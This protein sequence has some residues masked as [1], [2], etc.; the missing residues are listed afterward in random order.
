MRLFVESILRYGLPPKFLAALMKP[1]QK[2]VPKL[3]KI[4]ATT[5]GAGEPGRCYNNIAV[6]NCSGRHWQQVHRANRRRR[7]AFRSYILRWTSSICC[8]LQ[9]CI[10]VVKTALSPLAAC[11]KL[12]IC[13]A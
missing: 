2:T 12:L 9:T 3:R 4:L 13:Q 7:A 1:T 8:P 5:F 11:T 10:H 6:T